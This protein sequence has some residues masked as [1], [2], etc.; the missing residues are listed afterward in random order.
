ME[1]V[2]KIDGNRAPLHMFEV[3]QLANLI[4][5]VPVSLSLLTSPLNLSLSF[6]LLT[7]PSRSRC[8]LLLNPLLEEL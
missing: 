5:Q 8:S 4:P 2:Q 7:S 3:A 1:L 6:S